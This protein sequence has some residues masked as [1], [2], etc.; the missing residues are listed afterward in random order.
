MSLVVGIVNFVLLI[1]MFTNH[2]LLLGLSDKYEKMDSLTGT[3]CLDDLSYFNG[4][5]VIV[6]ALGKVKDFSDIRFS[7]L[8]SLNLSKAERKKRLQDGFHFDCNCLRCER[9]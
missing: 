4:K 7:Y 6:K 3:P 2:G 5:E 8:P 9:E 1:L